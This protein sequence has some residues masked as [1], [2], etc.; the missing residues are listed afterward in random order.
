VEV[1]ARDSVVLVR[2]SEDPDGATLAVRHGEW[3]TWVSKMRDTHQN[4]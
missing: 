1:L 3:R 2:S 4:P